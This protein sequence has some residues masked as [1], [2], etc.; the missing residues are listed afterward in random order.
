MNLSPMPS[1]RYYFVVLSRTAGRY[2]YLEKRVASIR[3]HRP[4]TEDYVGPKTTRSCRCPPRGGRACR[5]HALYWTSIAYLLW[6]DF[7][8]AQW[9]GEQQQALINWLHWG[10][11]IIVS[12]PDALE[13]LRN[14]FLRAY[15]PATVE[16]T[17]AFSAHDMEEL[18]YW[19]WAD[20]VGRSPQSGETLVRGEVEKGPASQLSSLHEQ[21]AG[22]AESRPR[23]DCRLGLPLDR[24]GV[25]RLAGLRLFF[26]RLPA[27]AAGAGLS[28][29]RHE[30]GNTKEANGRV[31]PAAT[32]G[33]CGWTPRK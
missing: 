10:G 16:K 15:L 9:D 25:D 31:G 11:Q 5:P 33:R 3:P 8:P 2:E 4:G 29:K 26:Q 22:G 28:G 18:S 30:G 24:T 12:G 27:A 20:G 17:Q 14:S 7:D 21:S 19:D 1:Y 13:Q 32:R 6:D 23:A